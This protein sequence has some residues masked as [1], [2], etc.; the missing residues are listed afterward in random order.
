MRVNR[1]QL[2]AV[3]GIAAGGQTLCAQDIDGFAL[4]KKVE[5]TYRNLQ[6]YEIKATDNGRVLMNG[7]VQEFHRPVLIRF[8]QPGKMRLDYGDDWGVRVVNGQFVWQYVARTNQYKKEALSTDPSDVR[9]WQEQFQDWEHMGEGAKDARILRE[10]PVEVN[11]SPVD[12]FVLEVTYR[13]YR[14]FPKDDKKKTFWI[15]KSR[16]VPVR[17][18]FQAKVATPDLKIPPPI[19]ASDFV[20]QSIELNKPIPNAVFDYA[21]PPAAMYSDSLVGSPIAAGRHGTDFALQDL[22]GEPVSSRDLRGKP[23]LLYF[24]ATWCLPCRADLPIIAKL[25][26]EFSRRGLIVLGL[27]DE[28]RP[29]VAN[30]LKEHPSGIRSL[31]DVD[32]K[33]ARS[34]NIGSIP[35]A[36]LIDKDG[37]VPWSSVL[38]SDNSLRA[39]LRKIGVF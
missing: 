33:I 35:T 5:E 27:N 30:Y 18:T 28:S 8:R 32:G 34:Y 1:R 10:E 2:L 14:E 31:I 29:A 6:S 16:Y 37:I 24:W 19:V 25:S 17:I 4:L 20:V 23:V 22:N 26:E 7:R 13:P 36:V 11:G 39:A 12:C 15:D 3:F 9:F 38:P 21:P